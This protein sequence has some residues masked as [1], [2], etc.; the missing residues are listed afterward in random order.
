M[1]KKMVKSSSEKIA[2]KKSTAKEREEL[3]IE[4]FVGLQKAMTNLSIKFE[5]LSENISRLLQVFE[6]AAK[7]IT[8]Q[9]GNREIDSNL[10][11]K[12]DSLIDQNKTIARGLVLIEEKL[13]A[14]PSRPSP[15]IRPKPLP[16]I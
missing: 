3:I 4:N 15:P 16:R 1:V 5:S 8:K 6:Q 7:D 13:K 14:S 11:K 10:I 2:G 12:I 9:G